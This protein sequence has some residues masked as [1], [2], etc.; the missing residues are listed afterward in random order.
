MID[1]CFT[2]TEH[3][4]ADAIKRVDIFHRRSIFI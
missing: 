1:E 3:A 2:L 4:D